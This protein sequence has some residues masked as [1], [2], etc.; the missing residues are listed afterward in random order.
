M[1]AAAEVPHVTA[2]RLPRRVVPEDEVI[3]AEE[4]AKIM[5]VC[6]E[7]QNSL[8]FPAGMAHVD[9]RDPPR[10]LL[11]SGR[12]VKKGTQKIIKRD[13]EKEVGPDAL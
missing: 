10:R 2:A 6:S 1:S 12:L 3:G 7:V 11:E 13:L 4:M 8:V 9:L 5:Q